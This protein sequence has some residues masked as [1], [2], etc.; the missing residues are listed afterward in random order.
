MVRRPRPGSPPR[1]RA[2]QRRL[3]PPRPSSPRHRRHPPLQGLAGACAGTASIP[4][5]LHK[6]VQAYWAA[7]GLV[8]GMHA[9]PATAT[10]NAPDHQAD[11]AQGTGV[12]WPRQQRHYAHSCPSQDK[13][14]GQP[15]VQCGV[16]I[17]VLS[18]WPS[19][20]RATPGQS[21][22]S[23]RARLWPVPLDASPSKVSFGGASSR[24]SKS[25]VVN[26]SAVQAR[27]HIVEVKVHAVK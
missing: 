10:T 15:D 18:G 24:F 8:I 23:Q 3:D 26:H 19:P 7:L 5:G 12:A 13:A 14:R 20:M 21:P 6:M 4:P 22:R 2:G 9:P 16:L 1:R 11:I 27:P 25:E 17:G